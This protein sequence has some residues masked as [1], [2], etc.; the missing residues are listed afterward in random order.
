MRRVSGC[1]GESCDEDRSYL[2]FGRLHNENSLIRLLPFKVC[3]LTETKDEGVKMGHVSSAL[4]K[5]K[6]RRVSERIRSKSLLAGI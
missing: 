5:L 2:Y 1:R 3:F 6:R 4:F